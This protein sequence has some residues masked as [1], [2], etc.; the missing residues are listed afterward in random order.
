MFETGYWRVF[1]WRGI[2]LRLHWT[3][4]IGALLFSGG[5]IAPLFWLGFFLLVLLHEIGHAVAVRR[6][7]YQVT[8]IDITGFGGMCR[9]SGSANSI[10]RSIIAWGGV[11]AQ[12][13]LLAATLVAII[14]F[15]SLRSGLTAQLVSVFVSTNL[16]LA[17][18]NLLPFPPLDGYQAWNLIPALRGPGGWRTLARVLLSRNPSARTAAWMR[19]PRT[20]EPVVP[21]WPRWLRWPWGK[22][23]A[24]KRAS[25]LTDVSSPRSGGSASD[26]S[27]MAPKELADLLH[28]IGSEAGKATK[29]S[30][31]RWN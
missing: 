7:R 31:K 8:A 24:S 22:K 21:W 11:A 18:I 25:H 28:S 19:D 15:P 2:P 9:W 16:W 29:G 20:R 4:P 10:E 30:K 17:A 13:G 27:G 26:K 3:L 12:L 23:S 5:V 1:S 14:A 6:F